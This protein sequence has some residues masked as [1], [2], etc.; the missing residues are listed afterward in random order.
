MVDCMHPTSVTI[1]KG[2]SKIGINT[3]HKSIVRMEEIDDLDAQV[4]GETRTYRRLMHNG[5]FHCV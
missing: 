3:M 4:Y 1:H 5:Q 2:F